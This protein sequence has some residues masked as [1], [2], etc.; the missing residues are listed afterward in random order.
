MK[1][2]KAQTFKA[3]SNHTNYR[4]INQRAADRVRGIRADRVIL[5]QASYFDHSMMQELFQEIDREIMRDFHIAST[6]LV[7]ENMLQD[8][9][10]WDS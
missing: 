4:V 5:D 3:R 2:D 10:R 8:I 9:I 7:N 6:V 1:Y